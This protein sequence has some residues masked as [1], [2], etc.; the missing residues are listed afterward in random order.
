MVGFCNVTRRCFDCFSGGNRRI[1]AESAKSPVSF[2]VAIGSFLQALQ[3][4]EAQ[5]KFEV[6]FTLFFLSFSSHEIE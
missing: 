2:S 1:P 4:A 3:S 6:H 5:R